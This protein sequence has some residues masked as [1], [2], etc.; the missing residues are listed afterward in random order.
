[1]LWLMVTFIGHHLMIVT[2]MQGF[3]KWNHSILLLASQDSAENK[4][5][6][7]LRQLWCKGEVRSINHQNQKK[8]SVSAS[9]AP[10]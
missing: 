8:Y 9:L 3:E 5:N 2:V 10:L 7:F 1:M 6:M 4:F